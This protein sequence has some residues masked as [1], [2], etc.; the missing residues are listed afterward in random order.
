MFNLIIGVIVIGGIGA[1]LAVLLEI[2]D[3]YI[4]DYG[5]SHIVINDEKDLLVKGG[6]PLLFSLMENHIFIP[7][8]CG[9]RGTCAYC[10]V[11]VLEGGGPV[12]PT[13]TPYL[14][15]EELQERVRL[16]CQLKVRGDLKIQIPEALFLIKEFK[17]KVEKIEQLTPDIMRIRLMIANSDEGIAFKPGQYIQLQ[18]PEYELCPESVYRAYSISSC[19]SDCFAI[20]LV[21]TKV[22]GG[23]CSTYVHDYL[24]EGEDLTINGP[25]GD[26]YLRDSDREILFIATGSGLAPIKA[27]L[28][29]MEK[30]KKPRKATLFFGAKTRKDLFFYDELRQLEKTISH[31]KFIPTLSRPQEDDHWDGEGGRVTNLIEKYIPNN[32]EIEAYICGSPAMVDSCETLLK[33]KGIPEERIF[34]DKFS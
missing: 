21:I 18:V 23:V 16:S 7:S 5:D 15:P 6:S 22:D 26:F 3:A 17:T 29:K 28:H 14:S 4:A 8:A 32:A 12:L 27:I 33:E 9:G 10:K 24:K 1:L 11:K 34:Y 19:S 30:E 2:A 25:H 31:F 13:E 20:E